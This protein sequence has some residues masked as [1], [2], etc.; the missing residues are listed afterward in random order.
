MSRSQLN[1]RTRIIAVAVG[2]LALAGAVTYATI[3]DSAGV[4]NGCYTRLTGALRVIDTGAGQTCLRFETPISWNQV[5]PQGPAG[6]TGPQGA[7]GPQGVQGDPGPAGPAGSALAYAHVSVVDYDTGEWTFDQDQSSTNITVE[8]AGDP[9]SPTA[10]AFCIG[11]TGGPVHA[12]VASLDSLPN[13]GGTVQAGVF[14]ASDCANW[15]H[16]SDVYVV[17][18]NQAQDGG[19]P[20]TNKSFY[21]IVQ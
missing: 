21:L 3:P 19:F 16:P 8:Q 17:T 10:G 13:R 7:Q 18:R 2:T 14:N 20:G 4:V 11:V 6:A 9:N 5:G 1:P 15:G 12:A